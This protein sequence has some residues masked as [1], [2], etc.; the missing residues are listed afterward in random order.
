M[1]V[2]IS[3]NGSGGIC[4]AC[5]SDPRDFNSIA[6]CISKNLEDA[7]NNPKPISLVLTCVTNKTG[8]QKRIIIPITKDNMRVWNHHGIYIELAVNKEGFL[9]ELKKQKII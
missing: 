4:L 5:A 6:E 9:H 2:A 1:S 8:S 3:S 7:I